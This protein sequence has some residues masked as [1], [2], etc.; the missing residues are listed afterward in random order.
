MVKV[1]GNEANKFQGELNNIFDWIEQLQEVDT[2][3]VEPL[4]S[5]SDQS[6][7]YSS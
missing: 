5:V 6:Y 2:E 7:S 4:Y 3:N 1:D